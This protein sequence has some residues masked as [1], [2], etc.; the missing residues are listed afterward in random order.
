MITQSSR[1]QSEIIHGHK[2]VEQAEAVWGWDSPAGRVRARRRAALIL[3]RLPKPLSGPVLEVGCGSG[4][5]TSQFARQIPDLVAIDLSAVLLRRARSQ[6]NF[7]AYCAADAEVLPF[8]S[9][10]FAA[11]IGSSVLHHLDLQIMLKELW[12]VLAPGGTIAFAEPNML[13]P[14]IVMQKNI[15]ALKERLGD[16]PDETAFVRWLLARQ[17][18]RQGF[19][20]V[21]NTP[22]DF[23]HPVVPSG[24]ISLIDRLGRRLEQVPIMREI[25]GSLVISGQ[26]P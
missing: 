4:V 24:F 16:S 17:L 14:Q 2:I 21:L 22:Y 12:R 9:G 20:D 7:D 25:A 5:F 18:R 13:N 1:K 10:K 6:S 3:E 15:P 19:T 26:K 8:A 23:L 11:V